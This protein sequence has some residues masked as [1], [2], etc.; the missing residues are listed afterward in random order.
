[1]ERGSAEVAPRPGT[2][3]REQLRH[4]AVAHSPTNHLPSVAC[5]E[6]QPGRSGV[7]QSV[8]APRRA[9]VLVR[10]AT[11]W[12]NWLVKHWLVKHAASGRQVR[13]YVPPSLPAFLLRCRQ[14]AAPSVVVCEFVRRRERCAV[15]WHPQSRRG[16]AVWRLAWQRAGRPS[17][18][19][20]Y[21]DVYVYAGPGDG[22]HVT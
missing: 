18:V 14:P 8:M 9:Q 7:K 16:W 6:R 11:G 10:R 21:K 17:A 2:S 1:M 22:K 19:P 13:R 4:D 15:E 12:T 20:D 5:G 3:T